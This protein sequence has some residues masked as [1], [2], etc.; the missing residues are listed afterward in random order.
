[1]SHNINSLGAISAPISEFT[2]KIKTAIE[3]ATDLSYRNKLQT[4]LEA[5]EKKIHSQQFSADPV[6]MTFAQTLNSNS[7]RTINVFMIKFRLYKMNDTLAVDYAITNGHI[8]ESVFL[9]SCPT[10]SARDF[11]MLIINEFRN[12]VQLTC[13]EKNSVANQGVTYR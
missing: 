3:M 10:A 1:M 6:E 12:Q 8:E 11:R 4:F 7:C 9:L 2:D 13:P 5:L